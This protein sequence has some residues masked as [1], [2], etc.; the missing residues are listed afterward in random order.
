MKR[1]GILTKGDE[2]MEG[3]EILFIR[4]TSHPN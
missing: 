3:L 1:K 2:E 4:G